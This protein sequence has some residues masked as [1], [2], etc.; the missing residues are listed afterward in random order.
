MFHPNETHGFKFHAEFSA[1]AAR[2][3]LFMVQGD[4]VPQTIVMEKREDDNLELSPLLSLDTISAQGLFDSLWEAG[5]RPKNR[6]SSDA[7]VAAKDEHIKD[8]R[9]VAFD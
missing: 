9:R 7:V 1:A 8:L 6:E 5:L 3:E 4:Y 2:F